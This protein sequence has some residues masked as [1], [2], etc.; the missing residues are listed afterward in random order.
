MAAQ[1]SNSF[2]G[3]AVYSTHLW[4]RSPAASAALKNVPLPARTES[5]GIRPELALTPYLRPSVKV[6]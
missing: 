6:T 2:A 4:C 3:V 5:S 1:E